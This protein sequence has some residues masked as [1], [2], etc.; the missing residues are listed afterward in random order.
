MTK[1]LSQQTHDERRVVELSRLFRSTA[2]ALTQKV[3]LSE[4]CTRI[5][6]S[7]FAVMEA[8]LLRG[9]LNQSELADHSRRTS[10]NMT[11]VVDNLERRGLV[12]RCG[13]ENDRR[14]VQ[15]CLTDEGH[16][17]IKSLL[18]DHNS[19]LMKIFDEFQ[20]LELDQLEGLVIRLNHGIKQH[21][22]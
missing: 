12:S 9:A 21:T 15:V 19:V 20:T 13:V 2:E 10:G 5:S 16:S 4:G 14:V 6:P 17:L 7:Q 8:L 18:P 11:V 22:S 3:P 1:M